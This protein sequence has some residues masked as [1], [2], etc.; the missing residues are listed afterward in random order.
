MM[1]TSAGTL[2]SDG[3]NSDDDGDDEEGLLLVLDVACVPS[4]SVYVCACSVVEQARWMNEC[5]GW[6]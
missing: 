5:T 3:S 2:E 6:F 4:L 1:M